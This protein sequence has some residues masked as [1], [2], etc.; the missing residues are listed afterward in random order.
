M[1]S[2]LRDEEL[3]R[4]TISRPAY[5]LTLIQRQLSQLPVDPSGAVLGGNELA[6]S[7]EAMITST[8]VGEV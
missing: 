1:K 8:D 5:K 4:A 6:A 7:V 2:V 3:L